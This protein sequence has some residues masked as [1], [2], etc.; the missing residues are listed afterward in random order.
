MMRIAILFIAALFLL[1][2]TAQAAEAFANA[3]V[4][5]RAGPDGGYPVV[6]VLKH[7]QRVELLGCIAGYQWCEVETRSGENGWVYAHYLDTNISGSSG[8][9]LT[10][11]QTG[12][13]GLKIITFNPRNYWNRYYRTKYFYPER[14]RWLPGETIYYYN[15]DDHHHHGHGHGKPRPR[16]QPQPEPEAAPPKYQPIPM[17]SRS[18]YNPLCPIGQNDC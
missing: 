15:N 16:P 3:K 9:S 4:N 7:G 6:D 1:P 8:Q 5:L 18:K 11:I 17:P 13:G 2:H 14:D 10:I 12:G